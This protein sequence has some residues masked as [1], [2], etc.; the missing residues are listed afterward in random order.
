MIEERKELDWKKIKIGDKSSTDFC[1]SPN[2]DWEGLNKIPEK[3][4]YELAHDLWTISVALSNRTIPFF[5]QWVDYRK[6]KIYYDEVC[7]KH[8]TEAKY[9]QEV[10]EDMINLNLMNEEKMLGM[11]KFLIALRDGKQYDWDDNTFRTRKDS[12]GIER[13]IM[14]DYDPISSEVKAWLSFKEN[15]PDGI[16]DHFGWC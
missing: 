7:A 6:D 1:D 16:L 14:G 5:C 12:C 11:K 9:Y 10:I 3:Q 4:F 8:D 15:Q 13:E 2:V